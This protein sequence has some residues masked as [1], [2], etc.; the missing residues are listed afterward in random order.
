ME[1][2]KSSPY[3]AGGFQLLFQV[4]D[5]I[6]MG[7]MLLNQHSQILQGILDPGDTMCW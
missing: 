7:T 4:R 5:Q 3:L 2:S 6:G 1:A